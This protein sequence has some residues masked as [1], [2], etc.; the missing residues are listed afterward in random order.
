MGPHGEGRRTPSAEAT[1]AG[2]A[3]PEVPK[4]ASRSILVPI[5]VAPATSAGAEVAAALHL[6]QLPGS[7]LSLLG[8]DF[9]RRLYHRIATTQGSFLLAAQGGGTP[10]GFVAG[11]TDVSGLYRRFL[12]RDGVPAAVH[13]AVPLAK[14]WRRGVETL[15][16]GSS[17]RSGVGLGAELLAIAVDPAWQGRGAGRLL[18]SSFLDELG[19]R[20]TDAAYVVVGAENTVAVGLYEQ[21]GF[22]VLDRFELHPGTESLL[23]Q[24]HRPSPSPFS[25][26]TTARP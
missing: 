5:T 14:K 25:A 15:R 19:V 13:A 4:S 1:G 23:L 12:L 7:F 16:H 6:S 18:V 24:W 11:S 26:A 3:G 8:R 9:L 22:I 10:V 20:G 21:A 2:V 17:G